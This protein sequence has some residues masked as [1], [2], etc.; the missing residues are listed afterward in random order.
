L[1]WTVKGSA[2]QGFASSIDK[3]DGAHTTYFLTY[4][5]TAST[6]DTQVIISIEERG[7]LVNRQFSVGIRQGYFLQP[8]MTSD[9]L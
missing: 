4:T 1:K 3:R 9:V 7:F 6:K 5:Y 2:Y 8:D